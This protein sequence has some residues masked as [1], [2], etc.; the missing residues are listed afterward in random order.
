MPAELEVSFD[1]G[2]TW[3]DNADEPI[4][5]PEIEDV[6]YPIKIR[7]TTA[8]ASTSG[9]F[10]TDGTYTAIA[11]LS[12]PTLTVT[13]GDT[14]NALSWTNV[15]NEDA[16]PGYTVESSA[17]GSSWSAET[18][19]AANVT[20]YTDT[21]LTNGVIRYYRVK[22]EGSG[23]YSDSG[24]GT[25][26][27]T[28]AAP[29]TATFYSV[30]GGD[31]VVQKS[32]AVWATQRGAAT[33]TSVDKTSAFGSC[34]QVQEYTGTYYIDRGFLS[35]DTSSIPDGAT[36]SSAVLHIYVNTKSDVGIGDS[37]VLVEGTQA[38]ATDLATADYDAFG[39]TELASRALSAITT[40]AYNTL[41]LNSSGLAIINKTGHTKLCTRSARDV[42][43]SAPGSGQ[44]SSVAIYWS[45]ETGTSKDPKLVVTYS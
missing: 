37:L 44:Y 2:S 18:T 7:Q 25:G 28:P 40:S 42:D 14:Q 17:D 10:V 39:S 38:S 16:S 19:T 26:N 23:R 41:T 1:G 22:A 27:G 11:A 4:T 35:F 43:N 13:P 34:M 6:N 12:T 5:A 45:D 36:I 33:G 15:A 30:A 24:W 31:G 9:S 29:V 8:A 20:T 3:Y 32:G 21:G